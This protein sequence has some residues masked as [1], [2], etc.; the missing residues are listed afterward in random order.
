[1]S[2]EPQWRRQQPEQLLSDML[3]LV[4]AGVL[5]YLSKSWRVQES[6]SCCPGRSGGA[7]LI[8]SR[9]TPSAVKV[10]WIRLEL[11]MLI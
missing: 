10:I 2:P 5:D 3:G 4:A 11:V 1:M 8:P 6:R 7:A 9:S